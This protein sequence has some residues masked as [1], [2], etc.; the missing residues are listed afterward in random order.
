MRIVTYNVTDWPKALRAITEGIEADVL[1][2]QERHMFLD[3]E[4]VRAQSA[5]KARGWAGIF[6][7]A[8]ASKGTATSSRYNTGGGSCPGEGPQHHQET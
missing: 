2:V 8:V 1:L 3:T 5:L 7:A 4:I 6:E